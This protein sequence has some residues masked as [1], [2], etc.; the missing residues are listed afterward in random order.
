MCLAGDKGG[1]AI[2]WLDLT[3]STPGI[4]PADGEVAES[5][6]VRAGGT[7]KYPFFFV[8]VFSVGETPE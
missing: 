7:P 1:V 6:S 2:S 4:C 8:E 5:G 3:P